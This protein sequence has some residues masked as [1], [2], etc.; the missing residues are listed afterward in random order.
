ME[1]IITVYKIVNE[2][3]GD[4][5]IG[6]SKDVMRRFREH[7]QPLVWKKQSN[8][9]MYQ[10]MR[11]Y[12]VDKFRFQILVPV[13]PEY[14][15]QVEQE[16]IDMLKPTYNKYNAK[17]ENVERKKETRK[18]YNK[19]YYKKYRNT[20]KGKETRK[21]CTKKYLQSEKGKESLRKSNAKY[22][23]KLC[24][25]NGETLTL[26]ALSSRLRKSGVE[27]PYIEAKKHLIQDK[28]N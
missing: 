11:K 26:C 20:D 5:Y 10:D 16:L 17:G 25:Y 6:S 18:K 24:S 15:K 7:K 1:K 23:N 27:H 8:N 3:T 13:M 2:V 28:N 14:L 22:A 4:F 21:K 9:P 12:G 19:T